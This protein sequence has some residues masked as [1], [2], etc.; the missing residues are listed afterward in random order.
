MYK[1]DGM[2]GIFVLERSAAFARA[3]VKWLAVAAVTGLI[4]GLVG[5]AFYLSVAKATELRGEIPWLLYLLPLAGVAIAWLYR[6][7]RMEHEGT[8]EIIGSI[9]SGEGV[10][11]VLVP[12]I[13]VS[14]AV[15]HLCGGS[16]GREGAALQIGG[17]LGF[18]AGRL[19]RL[20]GKEQRMATLCG[21]SALFSALFGTPLTAAVFA[22][23]VVSVGQLYYSG[24]VP[25]LAAALAAYGVTGL[26]GIAPTR[27]DIPFVALTADGLWRVAVLAMLCALVS[28]LF[29]VTMHKSAHLAAKLLPNPCLRAAAGGALIIALTLLLG[30]R[31][32][33]GAG[34]EVIAAA[35]ERGEARP[36]AF[37]LKL[38]FTAVTLACGFRG[39]EVVPAFFIGSTF[40]CAAGALLGLDPGFAAGIGLAAVF[41]GA[42]N[43]PVAS[44]FLS[45]ELFG[46]GEILYFALACC[47]SYML[48]GY[49]GL[50]S[51]QK[52]MYSKLRPE[53]ID[54]NAK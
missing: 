51:S 47:V 27:F 15:T 34:V 24:L 16:A 21:M 38:L 42:V 44:M 28:I 31:D 52:I 1:A 14:T 5:S 43:C 30:T 48:S 26:F 2:G 18:A 25:C 32:Y 23:E 39:G 41:C 19:F 35:L 8:S 4:G 50:Y 20:D 33:N 37:L 10:P 11:L 49:T 40:G 45:V 13:F 22:L 46:S 3:F 29:C 7:T 36:E 54:I 12:V 6:A 53:F 17:G 9:R